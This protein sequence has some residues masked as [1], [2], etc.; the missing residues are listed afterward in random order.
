MG[1]LM[2]KYIPKIYKK[3]ILDIDYNKLKDIGIKCILF[4]LDNTLLEVYKESLK[5][6]YCYLIK[7][8]K[9]DFK[10]IVISNNSSSKRVS[11][12]AKKLDVEYVKFAMKPL[13][14]GFRKVKKKYNLKK[15]EMALIGDQLMT[16]IMGGNKYGIYTVL[17]DPLAKKEL[18][19][20]GIN[21]FFERRA[22]KK[23][24]KNN[25]FKRGE[26]YG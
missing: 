23:L 20:T 24:A 25:L 2:N 5:K 11:Q 9:K 13:S 17:V 21:R 18:K 14:R 26:Y 6:E 16:D 12:V 7:K 22:L 3:S 4:D 10:I 15:E 1:E 19:V 8:L